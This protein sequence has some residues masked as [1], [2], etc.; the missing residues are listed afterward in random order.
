[1]SSIG[2]IIH[3]VIQLYLLILV[4]RIIIEMVRSFSRQFRPPQWF[5]VIAEP[6]FALTDPP[7]KAL[8]RLIPP[9]RLGQVGLD[10]SILVLFLVIDLLDYVVLRLLV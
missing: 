7:V 3:L 10:V 9:V 4:A 5:Y 2:Y 8:R 1:M 6:L